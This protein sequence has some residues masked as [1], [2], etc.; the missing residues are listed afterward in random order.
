MF[1]ADK[2]RDFH[3]SLSG[4]YGAIGSDMKEIRLA[5]QRYHNEIFSFE[6]LTVRLPEPLVKPREW[7]LEVVDASGRRTKHLQVFYPQRLA[8]CAAGD[9][10]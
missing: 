3:D 9:S 5:A 10:P 1:G 8:P 4:A 6:T 2:E 7:K